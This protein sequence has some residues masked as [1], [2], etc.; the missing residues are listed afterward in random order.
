MLVAAENAGRISLGFQRNRE[1]AELTEYRSKGKDRLAREQPGFQKRMQTRPSRFA[2]AMEISPS[3]EPLYPWEMARETY[4]HILD[5]LHEVH[6][7]AAPPAGQ[8]R[9]LA[10]P[11]SAA[12]GFS[13]GR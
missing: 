5:V 2:E 3:G 6:E 1:A 13:L 12:T 8:G 9:G 7:S 10:Q 4:S 11:L